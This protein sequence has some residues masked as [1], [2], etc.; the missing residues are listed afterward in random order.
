MVTVE[1]KVPALTRIAEKWKVVA[2]SALHALGEFARDR[3]ASEAAKK[4]HSTFADYE[5]GLNDARSVTH[6]PNSVEIRLV[7]AS[8]N[9]LERG[10]GPFDMKPGFLSAAK[11]HTKSGSPYMDIPFRHGLPGSTVLKP[12]SQSASAD[13]AAAVK[14]L[15]AAADS[16]KVRLKARTKPGAEQ[17][18]HHKVGLY[19]QLTR[20]PKTYEKATQPTFKTF[21]RVSVNSAAEAWKHPGYSGVHAFSA[22][23]KIVQTEA[24]KVFSLYA[25][26]MGV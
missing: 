6:A 8:A 16:Q 1:V 12:M 17:P 21:R 9:A 11:K 5:H 15:G 19:D 25:K 20:I 2:E 24:P 4:L 7:G 18:A 10:Y 13:M 23:M 3:I 14:K 26:K 22:A